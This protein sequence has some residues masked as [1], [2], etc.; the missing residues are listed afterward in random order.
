MTVKRWQLNKSHTHILEQPVSLPDPAPD[1]SQMQISRAISLSRIVLII[2]LVFLH[3]GSFPNSSMSP[4]HGL[5]I[6]EHRFATWFNSAVLFFFF[7]VVPL[8]SMISGWLFFSFPPE[9]VRLALQKRIARRFT[10]LYLPLVVW[11][12]AYLAVLY[13]LFLAYPQ[14]S[15]FSNMNRLNFDFFSAGWKEYGNALFAVTDLPL[16]FQFWF[17]RD[18][19]VTALISPIFWLMLRH[20]PWAGAVVLCFVWLGGWNLGIFIRSDVPFFFYMGALVRQKH[21]PLTI[22]LPATLGLISCYIVLASVRALVPYVIPIPADLTNPLWLDVATRSMR[23]L[24]VMGCWGLLYRLAQTPWGWRVGSYGGLAFFL[25]SAHWPL[26]AVVKA[27]I[28]QLMPADNGVWMIVHYCTSVSLT[29]M[30]GLGFGIA[31]AHKAPKIFAL[32]NGGRLLG[33]M[34]NASP[35]STQIHVGIAPLVKQAA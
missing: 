8:L 13:V 3:Y 9:D 18:L 32:M 25:H 21:L 24:G 10:S 27:A 31:L 15:F 35:P 34:P 4:F 16:A 19:F 14:A 6:H 28:W 29:V 17:V 26:L 11:N 30:I 33:Q 23:I 20:L 1:L 22:P 12:A 5:D 7:S 2:G